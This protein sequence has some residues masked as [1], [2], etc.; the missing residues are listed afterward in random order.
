M[1]STQRSGQGRRG[2]RAGVLPAALGRI[3]RMCKICG[4]ASGEMCVKWKTDKGDRL[5]IL[6]KLTELHRER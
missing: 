2:G 5:Y 4:A 1:I 3:Q 6:R